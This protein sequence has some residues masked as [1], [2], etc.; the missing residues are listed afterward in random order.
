MGIQ[1]NESVACPTICNKIICT[2][3]NYK[4]N[5]NCR[6][7]NENCFQKQ[8]ITKRQNFTNTNYNT[9]DNIYKII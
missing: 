7:C 1:T 3:T 5:Y 2:S 6:D 4:N 9:N 8:R